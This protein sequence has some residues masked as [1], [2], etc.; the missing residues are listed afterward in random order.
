MKAVER[1]QHRFGRMQ[2]EA[3]S[4][5]GMWDTRFFKGEMRDE[6]RKARPGHTPIRMRDGVG[7]GIGELIKSISML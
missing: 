2:D 4:R 6:D 7:T 5:G 1:V 3:Q